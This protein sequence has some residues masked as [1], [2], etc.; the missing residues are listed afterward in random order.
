MHICVLINNY[1]N[2]DDPQPQAR[3]SRGTPLG[4][5]HRY[6]P[7]VTAPGRNARGHMYRI[8][9]G[10]CIHLVH[11]IRSRGGAVEGRGAWP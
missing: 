11:T 7:S 2:Y 4:A 1:N 9:T 6:I 10:T 3:W 8:I 5:V